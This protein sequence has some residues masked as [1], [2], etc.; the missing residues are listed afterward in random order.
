MERNWGNMRV[1]RVLALLLIFVSTLSFGLTIYNILTTE[2][3]VGWAFFDMGW[4]HGNWWEGTW[5]STIWGGEHYNWFY[6]YYYESFVLPQS[7]LDV[8]SGSFLTG[9]YYNPLPSALL[10]LYLLVCGIVLW[11]VKTENQRP[12]WF[13]NR[14]LRDN[15]FVAG[16]ISLIGGGAL[17]LI[18]SSLLVYGANVRNDIYQAIYLRWVFPLAFLGMVLLALGIV[19][20]YFVIIENRRLPQFLEPQPPQQS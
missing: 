6:G 13:Y 12:S 3:N 16:A 14:N 7:L 10:G 11:F 5:S 20:L 2:W 19:R 17:S 18:L 1:M 9:S 4:E 8:L 15:K